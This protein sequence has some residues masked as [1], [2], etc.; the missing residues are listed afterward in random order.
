MKNLICEKDWEMVK[1]TL[2]RAQI[3]FHT[4]FDSHWDGESE[5]VYYDERIVVE[6]FTIQRKRSIN[7]EI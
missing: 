7:E 3:P 4:S 5:N 2:M 6:P 1:E